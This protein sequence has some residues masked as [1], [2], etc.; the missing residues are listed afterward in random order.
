[1][2]SVTKRFT[3]EAAHKLNL[4]YNSPC[5]SLHGHSYKV[6]ITVKSPELNENDMVVDFSTIK[7]IQKWV[8]TNWDHSLIVGC[9][10]HSISMSDNNKTVRLLYKNPTAEAFAKIL[11]DISIE[12]LK[13][14]FTNREYYISVSVWET[15]NNFA[16][17]EKI[18]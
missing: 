2:Y 13:P 3:F 11:Y 15:E 14:Y 18:G 10:D 6:S 7:D 12:M 4:N 5:N 1:M 17:F 16:T 8:D 9:N